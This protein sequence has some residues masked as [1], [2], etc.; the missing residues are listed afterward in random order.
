MMKENVIIHHLYIYYRHIIYREKNKKCA[1]LSSIISVWIVPCI[2]EL[3]VVFLDKRTHLNRRNLGF[4]H[5][6]LKFTFFGDL[7]D[8]CGISGVKCVE[9]GVADLGE[10]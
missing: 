9:P 6:V 10:F 5:K 8:I 3:L 1:G 4:V 7:V 2:S